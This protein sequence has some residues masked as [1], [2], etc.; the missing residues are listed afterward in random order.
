MASTFGLGQA[1]IV[2][3]LSQFRRLTYAGCVVYATFSVVDCLAEEFGLIPTPSSGYLW[4][5]GRYSRYHVISTGCW[6][7]TLCILTRGDVTPAAIFRSSFSGMFV[8]EGC[9]LETCRIGQMKEM[10]VLTPEHQFW[11]RLA[12][13]G[14]LTAPDWCFSPSKQAEGSVFPLGKEGRQVG[15]F[16]LNYTPSDVSFFPWRHAARGTCRGLLSFAD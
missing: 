15:L 7:G 16:R 6:H 11:I 10:G 1:L 14:L 9:T 5:L 4:R 2:A 8:W 13:A 12:D 3:L